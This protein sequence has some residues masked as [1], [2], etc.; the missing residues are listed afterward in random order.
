[1]AVPARAQ[2][3]AICSSPQLRD[4]QQLPPLLS[5]VSCVGA[6]F[7]DPGLGDGPRCRLPPRWRPAAPHERP[8]HSV[9]SNAGCFLPFSSPAS[10]GAG[11]QWAA[12]ASRPAGLPTVT[13]SVPVAVAGAQGHYL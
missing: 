13:Q 9:G 10:E 11:G 8:W 4:R 6:E 1:M 12:P 5:F 7:T 2:S 3:S